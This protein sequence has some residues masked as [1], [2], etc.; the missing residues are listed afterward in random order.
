[1]KIGIIGAVAQEV[2]LLFEALNEADRKVR[3]VQ[4]GPLEFREGVLGGCP[5]VVVTCGVGKVN[6]ALCAQIMISEF[7]VT[8]I[9]N[10][11]AAGGLASGLAVFDIVVSVDVVQHDFD[12]TAF[13][14]ELGRVP[15]TPSLEFKADPGLRSLALEAFA[16]IRKDGKGSKMVEGRIASGDVF[17]ADDA[18]RLKIQRTFDPACVEM[19]GGAI[20]QV[21][22][23]QGIPFIVLR[24]ISDLAGSQANISYD[25]FSR[26]AS[27]IS[28]RMIIAMLSSIT[29]RSPNA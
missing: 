28:A 25:D 12:T 22:A 24:S 14:Y 3:V 6:A 7:A 9:I 10:T 8:S 20:A 16:S 26:E 1:M 11:G 29:E 4:R 23:L 2:E 15:G 18:L 19:E 27:R 17:V 5:A 21:C 13:G